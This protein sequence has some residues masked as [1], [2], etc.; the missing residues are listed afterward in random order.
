[1]KCG[2]CIQFKDQ[3]IT[4]RN[5]NPTFINGST[6]TKTSLFETICCHRNAQACDDSVT[7]EEATFHQ[8]LRIC[9]HSKSA[10]TIDG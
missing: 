5:Y 9:P 1:M 7:V 6:N 3:L 10:T 2:I 4:L 8:C